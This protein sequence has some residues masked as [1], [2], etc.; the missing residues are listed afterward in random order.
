MVQPSIRT[1]FV[2][3]ASR[4][5]AQDD[6]AHRAEEFSNPSEILNTL[7][8]MPGMTVAD[9]GA[10]SGVYTLAA[11]PLVGEKGKV[12]AVDVQKDLLSRI[13]NEAVRR[14]HTQ[15]TII[16][17]D[18]ET[19]QGTRIKSDSV[20]LAILANVLFQCD[21]KLGAIREALRT[22]TP[23]GKLAVID[24]SD[25]FNGLGPIPAHVVTKEQAAALCETAGATLVREFPAGEHHYGLLYARPN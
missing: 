7:E 11:A 16:W 4:E 6:R 21:N 9:L 3:E 22:L 24:W 25:S 15:V 20:H 8:V 1:D 18:I 2:H 23:Q 5:V 13:Q 10:G 17:G 19:H 14:G 12:F